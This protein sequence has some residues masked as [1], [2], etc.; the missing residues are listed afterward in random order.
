[1]R[2]IFYTE[3]PKDPKSLKILL[4]DYLDKRSPKTYWS[5]NSEEQ[6]IS[7]RNRSIDDLILLA[8]HYF[9]GSTIKDVLNAYVEIHKDINTG[10]TS[11][12]FFVCGD[13]QKPVLMN[14]LI[15]ISS[16][17]KGILYKHHIDNSSNDSEY[18]MRQME[19]LIDD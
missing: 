2:T 18:T 6:C 14:Y 12:L 7:G 19:A 3:A 16:R 4:K 13:I 1:M 17:L 11:I 9:P 5:D 10:I 8:N 15:C